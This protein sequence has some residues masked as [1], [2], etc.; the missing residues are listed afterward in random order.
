MIAAALG[1]TA[2]ARL[3]SPSQAQAPAP[4]PAAAEAR[5]IAHDAYFYAYPLVK[6][7]LSIYQFA[8]DPGGSQYKGPVNQVNNVARVFTPADTG[9]ITPNSDTPYSFLILDLRA[10]PIVVTLPEIEPG[11]YYSLQVVDL[12]TNNVDYLGT[13]KDGN[14]GGRFLIAGPGWEGAVP[15]GVR[16]VVQLSTLL[17]ESQFR[18]QLLRP[19]DL[20]RV[21]AIQAG[22]RAE[23]LSAYL[24]RP[25]PPA[26]PSIAYPPISDASFDPQFWQY[27]NFLLQFCPPIPAE[28]AL[29]A[30]FATIGIEGGGPW[31][32][33]GLAPEVLAAVEAGGTEAR[34]EIAQSLAKVTTSVGLFG[35]P[36]A[37][38]GRYLQRA[39]GAMGGIYGNS[40][41]ETVYPNYALDEAGQRLDGSRSNYTLTFPPG[42]LP[43]VDAFWSV[44]M[45]DARTQFLVDNSLRRYLI[46]SSMLPDLKR[47]ADGGITLH[48]QHASPGAD[49]EANWL[50][51]PDG[52]IGVVMR[53]YLPKPEVLDGSWLPPAIRTAG[54]AR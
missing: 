4:P 21:K 18:T 43:P 7:Y 25:A 22:Y 27:A 19:S 9:V 34:Q 32:P 47:D 41:E 28:A 40:P 49:R 53:L 3:P 52:P 1:A 10:E 29:R 14:G 42:R 30:R 20:D 37:M 36:E 51:A 13:R 38:A 50:P 23:P 2:G 26:A 35:T 46:N 54:P 11:R 16:R 8:L 39:M 5:Q 17:A 31:P 12:Y 44:T 24:G 45:Y 6:N 33:A 48:L 15:P